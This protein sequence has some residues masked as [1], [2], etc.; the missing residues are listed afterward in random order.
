MTTKQ[1]GSQIKTNTSTQ[2]EPVLNLK[3]ASNPLLLAWASG[4]VS[5]LTQSERTALSPFSHRCQIG[6]GSALFKWKTAQ[7]E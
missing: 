7:Q 5:P 3:A 6:L 2:K 4:T 1:Q